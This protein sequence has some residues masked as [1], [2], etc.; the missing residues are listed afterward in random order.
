M[1]PGPHVLLVT[2]MVWT[3]VGITW[4]GVWAPLGG[5]P[6]FSHNMGIPLGLVC[7]RLTEVDPA[8]PQDGTT[9]D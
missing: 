5:R 9:G 8:Q 3:M 7:G 4:F 1:I 2:A 6:G